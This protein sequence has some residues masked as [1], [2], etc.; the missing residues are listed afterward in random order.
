MS[1]AEAPARATAAAAAEDADMG[2]TDAD[3]LERGDG[4]DDDEE[5]GLLAYAADDPPAAAQ[6]WGAAP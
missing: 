6:V 2:W 3:A 4:L 5:G 1:L